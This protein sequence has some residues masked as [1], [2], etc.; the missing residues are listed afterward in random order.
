[1]TTRGTLIAVRG[2][3]RQAEQLLYVE[4]SASADAEVQYFYRRVRSLEADIDR[5]LARSLSDD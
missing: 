3:L 2:Q 4:V 1:M 5:Y